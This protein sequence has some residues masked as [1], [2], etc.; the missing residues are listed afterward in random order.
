MGFLDDGIN[1]DNLSDTQRYKLAGNGWDINLVSRL[2][3]AMFKEELKE[4]EEC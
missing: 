3:K 1:L 2:F 4:K